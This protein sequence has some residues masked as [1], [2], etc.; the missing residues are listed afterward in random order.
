M[1]VFVSRALPGDTI[2][3]L[4][5]RDDVEVDVWEELAPPP[6]EILHDRVAGCDGLVSMLT[7]TVDAALF[8]AAPRLRVV[9]NVAVGVDNIDVAEATR[10]GIPVGHTP[11]I[12]TDATADI[13]W[14]LILASRRRL[15]EGVDV[16]RSGG[17]VPWYPEFMVSQ[18]VTGETLG[19]VGYGRIAR[20]VARRARG[21][22]M[23]IL[24]HTRTPPDDPDVTAVSLE[25]LLGCAD[26]VSLHCPL[27]P[28]TRHLV[29]AARLALMK[30][31]ATL[32]NTA[33]G[34]VVDEAALVEALRDGII[35]GAGLDVTE[36]EPLPPDS[37]LPGLANCV[38]VPHIG[39]A[40]VPTR[41]LMARRAVENAIAGL[42]GRPLPYTVNPE[43]VP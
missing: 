16:V 24:V 17:W 38:V 19:L 30:P 7:E 29:D 43:V 21:F 2:S 23:D 39:S 4:R 18:P 31:T 37:P 36:V 20:A 34:P 42:D 14:A 6:T 28:E 25:E 9:S 1:K 32:V 22:D 27:T 8:D 11:G 10:R 15:V 5:E 26:V 13:T 3:P 35:A 33:R 12:L 40:T 41:T